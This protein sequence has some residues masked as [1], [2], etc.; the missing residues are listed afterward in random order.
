VW[1]NYVRGSVHH[2][3]LRPDGGVDAVTREGDGFMLTRLTSRGEV[4]TTYGD[5]GRV[6]LG[7][8]RF[9]APWPTEEYPFTPRQI[10]DPATGAIV[11]IHTS[12]APETRARW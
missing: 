1:S 7:I 2:L 6:G 8:F 10:F 3:L 9:V 11:L 12:Y 5:A 4:D